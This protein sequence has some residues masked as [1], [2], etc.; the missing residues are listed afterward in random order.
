[1]RLQSS[2]STLD[3]L[4]AH[5]GTNAS[6]KGCGGIPGVESKW[7]FDLPSC[8]ACALGGFDE[9]RKWN[10]TITNV[11]TYGFPEPSD[12][13]MCKEPDLEAS[14]C[15]CAYS[16][17]RGSLPVAAATVRADAQPHVAPAWFPTT[18]GWTGKIKTFWFGANHTGLDSEATLALM[19]RHSVAGYGWQTGG[20]GEDGVASVGRGDAWGAA[21][22]SHAADYMHS[23][24]HGNVTVF[25]YRQIQVAL[26]L[27]A[28]NAIAADDPAKDHF[29]LHDDEGIC[30]ASQPWG[31][32]D[33][34]WN[35]SNP[36]ATAYWVDK[37]IGE[38][39]TDDS[40]T[41]NAPFSAVF[42][43][44][45]DQEY[46]GYGGSHTHHCNF[47]KFNNL[48]QQIA[49]TAMLPQVHTSPPTCVVEQSD[50]SHHV[51]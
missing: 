23:H 10:V 30:L 29:W 12:R 13:T 15:D 31:T 44:E 35:F 14:K 27:Y 21:A 1:M 16:G 42:F 17:P 50:E 37:V 8:Q 41:N 6:G 19:A 33:P 2:E 34:F 18:E 36:E 40:L 3:G 7:S 20:A 43:D 49:S 24:G 11:H 5:Y 25:Q 46:C 38:L 39:T 45:V 26:R 48:E 32:P 47:S 4:F 28:Q 51:V 22:V 9:G